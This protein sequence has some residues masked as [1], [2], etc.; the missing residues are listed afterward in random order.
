MN[1]V[2]TVV[3]STLPRIEFTKTGKTAYRQMMATIR[4]SRLFTFQLTLELS[5]YIA[6]HLKAGYSMI[7]TFDVRYDNNIFITVFCAGGVFYIDD[8]TMVGMIIGVRPVLVWMK[9]KDGYDYL[10]VHVLA[11]WAFQ[12]IPSEETV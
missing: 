8:V 3:P 5:E 1:T 12:T 7:E 9:K 11:G 10:I 4:K 6:L 2:N